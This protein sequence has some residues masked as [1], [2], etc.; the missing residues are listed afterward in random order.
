M[1]HGCELPMATGMILAQNE[2]NE[3]TRA[4]G[5]HVCLRSFLSHKFKGKLWRTAIGE[6]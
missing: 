3:N 6:L 5:K 2:Y 1:N 4:A